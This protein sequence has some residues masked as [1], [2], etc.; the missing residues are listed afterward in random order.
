MLTL[1]KIQNLA[2]VDNLSWEIGEGL[3][4]V[5]G[6]TGAGKSIIVGGLKLILGERADRTL[7]RTGA[8]SCTVEAVFSL[9]DTKE[10]GEFLEA[11]GFEPLEN[12]EIILKRSISTNG[13]NRQFINCSPATLTVLRDLGKLLV[14]LHGPHDH[15]SLLSSDRQLSMLDAFARAEKH[16]AAYRRSYATWRKARND[17]DEFRNAERIGEQELDLL[18]FQVSEIESAQLRPEDE[19]NLEREYR[20][21]TNSGKIRES[22]SQILKLLSTGDSS[23][24]GQLAEAQKLI[25]ELERLDPEAIDTTQ[26][27]DAARIELE[28]LA[29]GVES[30]LDAAEFDAEAVSELERRVDQLETL[31]RKYGNTVEEILVHGE[32]A[33]A[34][35]LRSEGSSEELARLEAEAANAR[36]ELDGAAKSLS[37]V[38]RK[39][40]P[41]VAKGISE[42]LA[43]LGFLRSK[44]D[45]RLSLESE[46]GPRG[47]ENIEFLFSPNPGEPSKP[48]RIIA[49]SGEMSRVMLAVKSAL[50]DQDSIPLMVF[51]EIDA[52]VG[53]EIAHAVGAKMASLG[54]RH[55][56]VAITHLPQVAAVAHCHYVV[57]KVVEGKKTRSLLREVEGHERIEEV[58]RM[59]GGGGKP[60]MALAGNLLAGRTA[61]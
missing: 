40:A 22:C 23:V 60:E 41:K 56:V 12:S 18:R 61:K 32:Q 17:L 11:K 48:L 54:S 51:D 8:E 5:T 13:A 37:A 53:G 31:K 7:I 29:R 57:C 16:L 14:D 55:Q 43:D 24:I 2:L 33:K 27:F 19:G 44:F 38:R 6:E 9:K 36:K 59:L 28:E 3:V 15:Q 30:Y 49:S 4:G 39:A 45:V 50:A 47:M 42:H 10:V 26:G 58:A 46:P 21:A 25:T 52:N 34:K 1:L 35:L 20:L